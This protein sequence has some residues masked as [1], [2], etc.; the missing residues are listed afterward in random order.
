MSDPAT[1]INADITKQV[2]SW[3]DWTKMHLPQSSDLPKI[4]SREPLPPWLENFPTTLEA[5]VYR[6][7]QLLD[8][9][10]QHLTADAIDVASRFTALRLY[11][12]LAG[13]FSEDYKCRDEI[14]EFFA[15][16]KGL[17]P[18]EIE[19]GRAGESEELEEIANWSE[20]EAFK[21]MKEFRNDLNLLVHH[22]KVEQ[23]P[24]QWRLVRWEI[25]N[26]YAIS[27]NGLF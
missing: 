14:M 23:I 10:F 9:F 26:S 13:L 5:V 16:E 6:R 17:E 11:C 18:I 21:L 25:L 8:C 22:L 20:T 19:M 2:Q 7:G 12:A 1:E 15:G 3:I 27:D 4:S 24:A